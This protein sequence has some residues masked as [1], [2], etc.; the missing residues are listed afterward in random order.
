MD[1]LTPARTWAAAE[2]PAVEVPSSHPDVDPDV[3]PHGMP[4]AQ[5]VTMFL[6]VVGPYRHPVA[7]DRLLGDL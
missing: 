4:L 2:A 1:L 5:R 6:S 3:E 7:L